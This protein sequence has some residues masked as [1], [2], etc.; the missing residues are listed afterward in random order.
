MGDAISKFGKKVL[1]V[2]G[3]FSAPNLGL[4]LNVIEPDATI[5]DVLTGNANPKD[6]IHNLDDFDFDIIPAS[7]YSKK[8]INPLK[9]KEKMKTLKRR[10]DVTLIDS[11]P[12]LDEETAG[13]MLASDDILLITT[14]DHPTISNTLK[15]IKLAKK[16]GVNIVGLI[17][18]KAYNKNFEIPLEDIE[19]TAEVPVLAVIPHDVNNLKALSQFK[20]S[21][22]HKPKSKGSSEYMKLGAALVGEKYDPVNLREMFN[23]IPKK[24][25]IN[26]EIYY[27]S[28]FDE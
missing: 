2:D 28:V 22:S 5:H 9:L 6:S 15:A 7:I 16:K 3:N 26:R 8:K 21:T 27:D 24:Q 13:V 18:N 10:Y 11:S 4:H 23:I 19:D 20:P 14:P 12:S 25:H 17:I 1:L